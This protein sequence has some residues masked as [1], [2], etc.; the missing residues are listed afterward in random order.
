MMTHKS[1]ILTDSKLGKENNKNKK[2]DLQVG[3]FIFIS[4]LQKRVLL[5]RIHL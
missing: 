4:E 3:F 2:T 5:F 1:I